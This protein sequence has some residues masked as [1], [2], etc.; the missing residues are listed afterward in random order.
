LE[1]RAFIKGAAASALAV[2]GAGALLAACGDG[3]QSTG[4][5]TTTAMPQ[6]PFDPDLPY[7]MQG[8]FAPVS[9]EVEAFDLEVTG[10]LPPELD[11]LYVR[12]GSN[13][14]GE[15]SPH[16]FLGDGMV[17]GVAMAGGQALWYRNRFVDTPL[18]RSGR[19]VLGT[20]GA[21]GG[22]NNQA[23][24]SVFHHGD[25]LLASGEIGLPYEISTEDL[26]TVGVYDY[27]GRLDTAM[28]AHPK[29]DPE[30]GRMHFFGYGFVQPYLTYHVA[31]PDGS[32]V[33][34]QQ[35]EVAGPTMMHDFAIT[36][37]DAIFWELPVVFDMDSA[38][39][40][41]NGEGDG[42][43]FLWD[44]SYGARIG[45]LPL[46]GSADEIRWVEIDPCY[47]FH[48]VNAHRDGDDVVMDVCKMRA[49]FED[50]G[51]LP[52]SNPHR[53]RVNTAGEQLTFSEEVLEE[54]TMDL[55]SLDRRFTGRP[56]EQSWFLL[57][58][59]VDDWPIEFVGLARREER[60][61]ALDVYDPGPGE[62]VNEV[63]FVPAGDGEGEGWMLAYSW[64]RARDA[65]DLI[66]LDALDVAAGPVAKVHLPARVPY[67]FHGTWIPNEV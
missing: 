4:S 43:G 34:S 46:D 39:Q 58:E 19:G 41:V 29:I 35:I 67:G 32:L 16:W 37:R 1:R 56:N 5:P 65:S 26:S 63:T 23:N 13:P 51:N 42:F 45:V 40:A 49:A 9:D 33:H 6:I 48:G 64:D 36:D 60:T 17:H 10:S 50:G 53:W 11:G 8:G 12:N 28:T 61:G 44:E 14:A 27:G 15:A 66:V 38:I 21:P 59:E 7:W 3:S 18:Y 31:D 22:E 47:V 55:P 57:S 2:G 25:K 62:R 30:T 54:R 20:G 52:A 24:V